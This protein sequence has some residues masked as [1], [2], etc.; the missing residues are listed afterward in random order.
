M[1]NAIVDVRMEVT[2]MEED[3]PAVRCALRGWFNTS[4]LAMVQRPRAR[5]IKTSKPKRLREQWMRV[6]L[7]P[8]TC[9]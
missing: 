2:C 7:C 8:E 3:A 5:G 9:R 1:K 6:A 4:E